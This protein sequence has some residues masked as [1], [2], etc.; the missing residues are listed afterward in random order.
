MTGLYH[1]WRDLRAREHVSVA[2]TRSLPRGVRAVAH[3]DALLMDAG[4]MQ[5]ERRST[6]AH[7]LVHLDRGDAE[8]QPARVEREVEEEAARR[9][10]PIDHLI[11]ALL[12]SQDEHELSEELWVDRAIVRARLEGLTDAERDEVEAAMDR[13]EEAL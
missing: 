10:I 12:W 9:L 13:R 4:Q 11:D 1:P 3:G 5:A 8:C 7:E 6:L 2:W